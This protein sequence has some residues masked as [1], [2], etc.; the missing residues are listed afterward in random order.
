MRPGPALRLVGQTYIQGRRGQQDVSGLRDVRRVQAVVVGH[1]GVI[2]VLERHY[3]RDECVD[4]D[5]KG[6]QQISLLGKESPERCKKKATMGIF[7]F[8]FLLV[9]VTHLENGEH[10]AA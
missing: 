5:P 8:F 3:V 1:V 10:D 7:F 4:R 2:V 9:S 6:L